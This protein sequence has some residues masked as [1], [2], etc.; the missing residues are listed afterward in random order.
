MLE[1]ILYLVVFGI[2]VYVSFYAA[3]GLVM[4]WTGCNKETAKKSIQNWISP[5]V[6]YVLAN[7]PTF[8]QEVWTNVEKI[9]GTNRFADLVSLSETCIDYPFLVFGFNSNLPCVKITVIPADDSE[10]IRI[11]NTL[12][13]LLKRYLRVNGLSDITAVKWGIR[14]D[15]EIPYLSI[16]YTQTED[17]VMLLK[18]TLL[19]NRQTTL[20]RYAPIKDDEESED[21]NE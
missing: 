3:C 10:R 4:L 6:T 12:K 21:L 16:I 15:L 1:L 18:R 14:S 17:Q 20:Q 9:I 7:D 8:T 19:E 13:N 2:I 11:E 5:K